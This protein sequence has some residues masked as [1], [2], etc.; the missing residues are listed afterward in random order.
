MAA[1]GIPFTCIATNIRERTACRN[2]GQQAVVNVLGGNTMGKTCSGHCDEDR[3]GQEKSAEL[4]SQITHFS[5]YI[6]AV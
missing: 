4:M 3:E 5:G 2:I 1:T 6:V